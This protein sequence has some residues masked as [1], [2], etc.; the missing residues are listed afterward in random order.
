[1][2]VPPSV[3]RS[4]RPVVTFLM[5]L[6]V[7]RPLRTFVFGLKTP[8]SEVFVPPLSTSSPSVVHSKG[9]LSRIRPS[10]VVSSCLPKVKGSKDFILTRNDIV[11]VSDMC[12]RI[13]VYYVI[14]LTRYRR[15]LCQHKV[16]GTSFTISVFDPPS[17]RGL[18]SRTD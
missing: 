14:I 15:V 5:S 11:T 2:C 4:D 13:F 12:W 16:T 18:S 6:T 9:I 7:V 1:M 3:F 8:S 10:S 17:S